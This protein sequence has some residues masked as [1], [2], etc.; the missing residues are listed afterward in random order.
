MFTFSFAIFRCVTWCGEDSHQTNVFSGFLNREAER[1]APKAVIQ[2]L[3]RSPPPT[4]PEPDSDEPV[5]PRPASENSD[6]GSPRAQRSR[7]LSISSVW[8]TISAASTS[9]R[10]STSQR[11]DMKQWKVEVCMQ[12]RAHDHKH[13]LYFM[14]ISPTKFFGQLRRETLC[15]SWRSGNATLR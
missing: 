13:L 5:S 7:A 4:S 8:S 2:Q 1:L 12:R 6:Q 15:S 14:H 3:R 9:P 11:K 10:S